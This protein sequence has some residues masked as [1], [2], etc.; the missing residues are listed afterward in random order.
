MAFPKSDE[1]PRRRAREHPGLLAYV[2]LSDVSGDGLT[3]SGSGHAGVRPVEMVPGTYSSRSLAVGRRRNPLTWNGGAVWL[4]LALAVCSLACSRSKAPVTPA[5]VIAAKPA[6]GTPVPAAPDSS[7]RKPEP[8]SPALAPVVPRDYRLP[9]A[10]GKTEAVAGVLDILQGLQDFDS[11]GRNRSER[12]LS[13]ELAERDVNEYLAYSLKE[14]PRPGIRQATVRFLGQNHITTLV[15]IDFSDVDQ[16]V[17][18][19]I[20]ALL[21]PVLRGSRTVAVDVVFEVQDSAITF[22]LEP[23]S[24][25]EGG[26]M[27]RNIVGSVL[28]IL[29]QHQ[30]ERFDTNLP[31]P[32]PFGLRTIWTTDRVLGGKT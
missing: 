25:P 31:I 10:G 1:H 17:P 23:S 5:P 7:V 21:K 20:P 22:H 11:H 14:A 13:F 9:P 15:A 30:P 27:V 8:L 16:W 32:L 3:L 24:A 6:P 12:Q 28:D 4:V 26:A 19:L 29:A 2:I 18:G